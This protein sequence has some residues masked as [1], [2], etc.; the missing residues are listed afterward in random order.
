MFFL[1]GGWVIAA[2]VDFCWRPEGK[3]I[4]P[5]GSISELS[6]PNGQ[7]PA[8]SIP[9]NVLYLFISYPV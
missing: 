9:V 3:F 5:G 4:S 6:Q 1:D 2:I 8:I 7:P